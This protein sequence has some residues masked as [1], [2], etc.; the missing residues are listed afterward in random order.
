M[1]IQSLMLTCKLI[2]IYYMFPGFK[3]AGD[4]D[5]FKKDYITYFS[6]TT[7]VKGV[8][9][10]KRSE[11]K[12]MRILWLIAVMGFLSVAA[13]QV[14]YLLSEFL[15]FPSTTN[16]K[17]EVLTANN[18]YK[19]IPPQITICNIHPLSSDAQAISEKN[20][21]PTVIEYLDKLENLRDCSSCTEIE[22]QELNDLIKRGN[23]AEGYYQYIGPEAASQLSHQQ[24]SMIVNC[25]VNLLYGY[26]A[27]P[28]PCIAAGG[29][30]TESKWF[31]SS[32][33]NCYKYVIH[34]EK[35]ILTDIG[36]SLVIYLDTFNEME[37]PSS[38]QSDHPNGVKL[39]IDTSDKIPFS[40]MT[41]FAVEPGTHTYIEIGQQIRQYK[42]E[43]Y[44]QCISSGSLSNNEAVSA[45]YTQRA[46]VVLCIERQI[47]DICECQEVDSVNI[48][49]TIEPEL[50][51]GKHFCE[52]V[53][54]SSKQLIENIECVAKN[55]ARVQAQCE[56]DCTPTCSDVFFQSKV[57]KTKWPL[58]DYIEEFYNGYIKGRPYE[59]KFPKPGNDSLYDMVIE[60]FVYLTVNHGNPTIVQFNDTATITTSNFLSRLGGALNLWAGITIIVIMEIIDLIYRV[61]WFSLCSKKEDE[62]STPSVKV[63]TIAIE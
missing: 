23:T 15:N 45:V 43:P 34:N 31:S 17:E 63:Q 1:L 19:I 52:D 61:L 3:M 11:K 32:H 39:S 48:L 44:S 51:K 59:S 16:L 2:F 49:T 54:L 29:L 22:Q 21:I 27:Q 55:R 14:Y 60:H 38:I 5:I 28:A 56:K 46:C 8:A 36:L 7:S 62:D 9:R 30:T 35:T 20:N 18:L 58:P 26:W 4:D 6:L 10:I 33:F 12:C 57:S 37:I 24:G 47:L 13:T 25:N 42:E 41:E 50:T 40:S 53:S